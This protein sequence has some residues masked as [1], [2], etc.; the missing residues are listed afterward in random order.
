MLNE[1]AGVEAD[2]AGSDLDT[3]VK[4]DESVRSAD[5]QDDTDWK[6]IAEQ[7]RDRAENY[8][9]ALT[10]KRQL[11][12]TP[13]PVVEEPEEDD[14]KP[15]TRSELRKVLQEEVAPIVSQNKV[16]S[17]L[18]STVKDPEK[19]KLVKLYYDTRIR[20]TGTSDEAVRQD[21]ESALAIADAHKYRKAAAE[22]TR[23]QQKDTT[24]PI[25]GSGSDRGGDQKNHKFSADQE[26]VLTATAQRLGQ[27]PKKFIEAAW[28]NAQ[29]K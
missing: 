21:I 10:Q 25:S 29:G 28:K 3:G 19:R 12:K 22:I 4:T 1:N 17:V 13:S 7:E 26:K 16:E 15:L 20:Q 14:D 18:E 11:R 24:P 9:T 2:E 8:K 5:S 27:D 23:A 6:A